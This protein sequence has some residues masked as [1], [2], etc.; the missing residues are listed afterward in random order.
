MDKHSTRLRPADQLQELFRSTG[1]DLT[2]PVT[3]TCNVGVTACIVAMAAF[4]LGK[5]D[6]AVFDGSWDEFSQKA[7]DNLVHINIYNKT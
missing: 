4:L 5:E 1:I 7:P 6:V 3:T 2:K